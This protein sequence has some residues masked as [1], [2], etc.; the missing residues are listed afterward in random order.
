MKKLS[1]CCSELSLADTTKLCEA[2]AKNSTLQTVTGEEVNESLVADMYKVLRETGTDQR[3][4]FRSIIKSPFALQ[5]ALEHCHEL[6]EVDYCPTPRS[7]TG[8]L[9]SVFGCYFIDELDSEDEDCIHRYSPVPKT[10]GSP[11]PELPAFSCLTLCSQLVELQITLAEEMSTS[12]AE[13]LARFLS[14]TKKLR[15]ADLNF[16]TTVFGYY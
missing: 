5:E 9:N 12:C 1:L 11:A 14:S 2:L 4:K 16:P 3:M 10:D 8:T 7:V 13:L 6:T 15:H